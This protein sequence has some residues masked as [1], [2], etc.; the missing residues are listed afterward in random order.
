MSHLTEYVTLL[1]SVFM[2]FSGYPLCEKDDFISEIYLSK[3][4]SSEYIR[5]SLRAWL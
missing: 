1:V 4:F 3:S 5:L 2:S